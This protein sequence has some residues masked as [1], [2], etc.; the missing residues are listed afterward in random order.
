M[1]PIWKAII[2]KLIGW[3]KSDADKQ[4]LIDSAIQKNYIEYVEAS[5]TPGGAIIISVTH[6]NPNLAA[7]YANKIMELVRQ[8]VATE[9]E[10]SKEMRLS[11]LA[12][13]LADA[14]QD[15]EAAQQKV[16]NYTLGNSAA[17][18]ENFLVGSLQL[19]TLRLE[20]REAEEFLSVLKTLRELVEFGD[21]NLGAYEALRVGTPLVDDLDFRRIMG[22]SETISAWSW[23][24]LETIESVSETLSDRISRLDVD[25]TNIEDS[26]MSYAANAEDQARLLRDAK[27]AEATFT[28]LTEQVKSQTLVAGFKPDTFTVFAYATP[29]IYPSSPKRN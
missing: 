18:Q 4:S 3:E 19:D 10:K 12:E 20:R 5:Q 1:D 7:E 23:P 29:P 16:K 24:T 17:A 8:T 15:M 6:E 13:T 22:M 9:E 26:A 2:K 28:V 25:I 27:I 21:L 14:L 11:Y